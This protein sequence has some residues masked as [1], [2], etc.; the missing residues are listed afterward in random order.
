MCF[1]ITVCN[2]KPLVADASDLMH[3]AGGRP[4]R[5]VA[6]F[7]IETEEGGAVFYRPEIAVGLSALAPVHGRR[8]ATPPDRARPLRPVR[9]PARR[10]PIA[11]SAMRTDHRGY[12]GPRRP[13]PQP[14]RLRGAGRGDHVLRPLRFPGQRLRGRGLHRRRGVPRRLVRWRHRSRAVLAPPR[15]ARPGRRPRPQPFS[16]PLARVT[17]SKVSLVI[18]PGPRGDTGCD[19]T[20]WAELEMR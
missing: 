15:P 4:Q 6:R 10:P 9:S 12:P 16:A 5:R 13:C 11:R 8:P 20:I 17:S 7:R 2:H 3:L 18:D 1:P 14:A 19:W